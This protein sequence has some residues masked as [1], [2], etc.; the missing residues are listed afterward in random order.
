M[1]L[2]SG[3][4]T[5]RM[6][7]CLTLQPVLLTSILYCSLQ[8]FTNV[9][10]I[11]YGSVSQGLKSQ[12]GSENT[13]FTFSYSLDFT[14]IPLSLTKAYNLPSCSVDLSSKIYFESFPFVPDSHFHHPSFKPLEYY[15]LWL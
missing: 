4:D 10:A 8:V 3:R 7:V 2:V 12:D 14:S 1:W 13:C 9:A 15:D 11:V 5:I 6:Q